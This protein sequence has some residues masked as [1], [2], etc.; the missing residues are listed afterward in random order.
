MELTAEQKMQV[1]KGIQVLPMYLKN[2]IE[3]RLTLQCSK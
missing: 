3:K 1:T 2:C